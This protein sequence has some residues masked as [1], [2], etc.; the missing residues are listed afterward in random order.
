MIRIITLWR[1]RQCFG[2]RIAPWLPLLL[3]LLLFW[4]S[5]FS[6]QGGQGIS[7]LA[8]ALALLGLDSD[9]SSRDEL[10][11]AFRAAAKAAHPDVGGSAEDFRRIREAYS[12]LRRDLQ[13]TG[14]REAGR[15]LKL[16]QRKWEQWEEDVET[17]NE[18]AQE[19]DVV[20]WRSAQAEPWQLAVVL[21][22]QVVYE[23]S[24]G[25]HGWMYLQPMTQRPGLRVFDVDEEADM[26]QVEPVSLDGVNWAFAAARS[27]AERA[28]EVET[29]GY[30]PP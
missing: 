20:F 30:L 29:P 26:E 21:A 7:S 17:G 19:N 16:A 3:F 15:E 12:L 23:P 8:E 1:K 5:C 18:L 28:W 9:G 6:V 2:M 14:L 11:A 25:P 24:S 4:P 13:H 27:V 10:R 22:V